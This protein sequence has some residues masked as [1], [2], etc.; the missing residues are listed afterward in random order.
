MTGATGFVGRH[1]VSW[2]G[3]TGHEVVPA[4]RR[5]SGLLR[6][7]A[8]GEIDGT[9]DWSKALSG[10]DAVI[11]CAAVSAGAFMTVNRD[12]SMAL[13]KAAAGRVKTFIHVSTIKVLGDTTSDPLDES[14]P[15]NPADLY[16]R[17]KAEAEL[18]VRR[19]LET[20]S[21]ALTIIRPPLVY[22]KGGHGNF[23][24]LAALVRRGIPLPFGAIR[25]RRSL[26]HVENLCHALTR[27][28]EAEAGVYHVTDGRDIS[29]P[30]WVRLAA[31]AQRVPARVRDGDPRQARARRAFA[32]PL[33]PGGLAQQLPRHVGAR[34]RRQRGQ[35]GDARQVAPPDVEQDRGQLV[36]R[37]PAPRRGRDQRVELERQ[38]PRG[39]QRRRVGPGPED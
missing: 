22:G 39:L 11:H 34:I 1:A 33:Q 12:G 4:V 18:A 7:I 16:G 31:A 10:I 8:I 19:A 13:A 26:I 2:L 6:E 5:A 24:K 9:T 25:N 29:T 23:E 38:R 28:L 14:A 15:L 27:A 17:S 30:E 21:T 37:V 3:Q 35:R 20:S 32:E 36:P